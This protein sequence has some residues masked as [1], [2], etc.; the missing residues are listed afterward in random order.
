M[1]YPHKWLPISCRSSAG[2]GSSPAE[3]PTFY[4]CRG[5]KCDVLSTTTEPIPG[6]KIGSDLVNVHSSQPVF[7][8]VVAFCKHQL[9]KH[10]IAQVGAM[11]PDIKSSM[12][13]YAFCE[14]RCGWCT[15][16]KLQKRLYGFIMVKL[17]NSFP[18]LV[19]ST[20]A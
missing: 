2:Q 4:H 9:A 16:R 1:A 15:E 12:P 8:L 14:C 11:W 19:S 13:K 5:W 7:L 3:R 20:H 17:W 18:F 10:F 6:N